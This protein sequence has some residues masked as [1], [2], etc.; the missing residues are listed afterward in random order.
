VAEARLGGKGFMVETPKDIRGALDEAMNH[1]GPVLVN[2]VI[3][4]VAASKLLTLHDNRAAP[5]A[6]APTLAIIGNFQ[7]QVLASGPY[8]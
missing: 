3:S 6:A 1:R 2:V 8:P 5:L 4:Q 7:V